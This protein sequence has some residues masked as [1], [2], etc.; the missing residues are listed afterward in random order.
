MIKEN[1]IIPTDDTVKMPVEN[2]A[3][4]IMKVA[5]KGADMLQSAL[6][7][8]GTVAQKSN[9][10]AGEKGYLQCQ[11]P[12]IMITMPNLSLPDNYAHYYGFPCNMT[13]KLSDLSG[14]TKISDCHLEGFTCTKSELDEIEQLLKEGIY[15]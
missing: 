15:L 8:N 5:D 1:K 3:Q 11:V 9:G 2:K 10:G 6:N 4:Q 7:N 13:L 12:F 14:F